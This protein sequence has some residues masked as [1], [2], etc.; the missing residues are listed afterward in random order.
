MGASDK[1]GQLFGVPAKRENVAE[2]GTRRAAEVQRLVRR[3][4]V[5][6]PAKETLTSK[7]AKALFLKNSKP[8]RT[9][10]RLSSR[11]SVERRNLLSLK[12]SERGLRA[13]KRIRKVMREAR[14]QEINSYALVFF[15]SPILETRGNFPTRACVSSAGNDE[16]PLCVPPL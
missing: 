14:K 9:A 11:N 10:Q 13:G 8:R 12:R 5:T 15:P 6:D 16:T 7:S 3:E 2:I 1:V 4:K